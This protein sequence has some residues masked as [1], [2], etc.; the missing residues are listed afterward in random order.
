L[1]TASPTIAG[2]PCGIEFVSLILYAS[3][4][5]FSLIGSMD[6]P[7]GLASQNCLI[8]D[9]RLA[10]CTLALSILP[11]ELS[12]GSG[13]SLFSHTDPNSKERRKGCKD[14]RR[15]HVPILRIVSTG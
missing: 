8:L 11:R 2:N 6:L 5:G 12:N 3:S 7:Y 15:R 9:S 10:M 4:L 1:L 13:I 14:E